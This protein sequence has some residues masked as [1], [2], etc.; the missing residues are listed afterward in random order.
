M[1]NKSLRALCAPKWRGRLVLLGVVWAG[2]AF[3]YYGAIIAVS[4]VFSSEAADAAP[5]E[6]SS[7]PINTNNNNNK[8][9]TTLITLPFL[10]V[11]RPKYWV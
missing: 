5:I 3:L 11:H 2:T 7:I 6:D 8:A 10:P 9:G 1:G 4:L